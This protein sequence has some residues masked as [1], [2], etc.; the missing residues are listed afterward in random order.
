MEQ[1]FP[2]Q[3]IRLCDREIVGRIITRPYDEVAAAFIIY[4]RY[5]PLLRKICLKVFDNNAAWYGDC[6]SDL[7]MYLKGENGDWDKLRN[8]EWRS[9][10]AAWLGRIAS[11]RFAE[12]KP[13]L[14]GNSKKILSIDSMEKQET[15]IQLPDKGIEEYAVRERNVLLMEAIGLLDIPEQKFVILK[16]L[17]GYSSREI[18]ILLQKNWE[19]HG[20]VKYNNKRQIV[21]PD[22]A[23]IDVTAKRAKNNLALIIK[24]LQ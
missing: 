8:F 23:Y 18:A 19:R 12:I 6:Q 24:K 7:Y 13:L 16:R 11:R 22:A 1:G 14:T 17:Q 21:V 20:V 2:N 15:P 9:G 5:S 10:L 4:N 3:Y